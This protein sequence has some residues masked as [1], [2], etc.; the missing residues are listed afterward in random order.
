MK[1]I[2]L[3]IMF[4]IIQTI[5]P[6][7]VI[8]DFDSIWDVKNDDFWTEIEK[9]NKTF[10][11]Q[12][13]QKLDAQIELDLEA[14]SY[15]IDLIDA[16]NTGL[17]NSSTYK[18]SKLQKKYSDWEFRNKLSEYV[19]D[20]KYGFELTD[21]KGE[22]LVGGILPRSIHETVYSST[23]STEW[24]IFSS[25]R[26]FEIIQL[27][28]QQ[29]QQMHK[30]NYTK[31][32]LIYRIATAYYELL[33]KKFEIEI[34]RYNI[35]EL[36]EQLKYNKALYE[37]GNGT[38]F[39]IL[40]AESEVEAAKADYQNSIFSLKIA[41]TKLANT[42]GY[43]IFANIQPKEK[44]IHKLE[45]VDEN[46]T[47]DVL[48]VNAINVREDLKAK[49]NSIKAL[50]AKRDLNAADIMPSVSLIWQRAYVGTVSTGLRGNDTY[51]LIVN[52][53]LGKNLGLNSF[54]KYKMDDANYKIAKTELDKMTTD[55]QKNIT[56]NYFGAKTGNEIINTKNKQI[57]STKE[58]LRQAIARMK[59]GEATYIDVL[60]ANRLKTQARIELISAIVN[61]N[62]TQLSQLFEIGLMS[63][64]EIKKNYEKAQNNI[65]K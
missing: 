18:I 24:N 53:P 34:Y 42:V 39:D 61:Y 62:K 46:I 59:I 9:E 38:R 4:F 41:Q 60:D 26:I 37:I 14:Q 30:Q 33:Q 1:K 19:P 12:K 2:M 63:F 29:K 25:K 8:A 22:F 21:L 13:N 64:L 10:D 20:I 47:P 11:Q 65:N 23:F 52:M 32:E 40:R 58:G 16:I 56:D 5:S 54:T 3:I 36:E 6:Q 35:L 50:K 51:G 43:P 15:E 44:I 48:F 28:N 7:Q 45:L 27:K 31:E 17:K 49:K 55:I 57:I